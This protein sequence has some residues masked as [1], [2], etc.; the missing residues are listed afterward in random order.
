M[1][2]GTAWTEDRLRMRPHRW[3]GFGL[4]TALAT[5]L[6]A[7]H[8][9]YPLLTSHSPHPQLPW[10]GEVP[11]PSAFVFDLGV[12][13]LVVGFTVLVLV[14]LAHQSVR[15]HRVAQDAGP[16]PGP[17]PQDPEPA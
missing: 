9:G 5:G 17:A 12:F 10:L 1:A 4:L 2:G 7:W 13:A 6:G 3:I 16:Q 15:S 14:S 8:F 11:M